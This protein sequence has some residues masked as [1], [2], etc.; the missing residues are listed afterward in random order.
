M[1]LAPSLIGLELLIDRH[2]SFTRGKSFP[3]LAKEEMHP[4]ERQGGGYTPSWVPYVSYP[5]T[6][7]VLTTISKWPFGFQAGQKSSVQG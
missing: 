5:S 3:R 7:I 1:Q 2:A 4:K 6:L